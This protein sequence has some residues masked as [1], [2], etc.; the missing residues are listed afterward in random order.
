MLI[1]KDNRPGPRATLGEKWPESPLMV[2]SGNRK[3]IL[4][5]YLQIIRAK[6]EV[7]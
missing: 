5:S 4:G 6:K 3:C 7:L 1:G 2:W